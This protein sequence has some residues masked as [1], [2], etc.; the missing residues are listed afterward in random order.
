MNCS[1]CNT[2]Y[3]QTDKFC[4]E[5]GE[6]NPQAQKQ[7]TTP[8]AATPAASDNIFSHY[9][10][11]GTG[12]LIK[13][14]W[15][16]FAANVA[17]WIGIIL[18]M[19][20]IN[21]IP[22]LGSLSSIIIAIFIIPYSYMCLVRYEKNQKTSFND[23]VDAF[24]NIFS[25][26]FIN[27]ILSFLFLI[28]FILIIMVIFILTYSFSNLFVLY[29]IVLFTSVLLLLILVP[30][31][32][33]SY[34]GVY[35]NDYGVIESIS[36]GFSVI[37][38]NIVPIIINL[39]VMGIIILISLIPLGLGAFITFPMTYILLAAL[40]IKFTGGGKTNI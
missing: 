33:F 19:I 24:K 21:I 14:S 5:C 2:E 9:A 16:V 7:E 28:F 26:I 30:L 18:L 40:Y 22:I 15:N 38:S 34:L 37:L 11:L 23:D 25:F 12:D 29:I 32:S 4:P 31:L 27:L 13:L 6:P 3:N 36:K 39:I 1:K 20:I 35:A 10:G 8:V 17:V